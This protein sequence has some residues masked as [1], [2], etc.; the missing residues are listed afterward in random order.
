MMSTWLL[1]LKRG[2]V[3]VGSFHNLNRHALTWFWK[4]VRGFRLELVSWNGFFCRTGFSICF[5]AFELGLSRKLFLHHICYFLN[6][7]V[8]YWFLLLRLLALWLKQGCNFVFLLRTRAHHIYL[9]KVITT[10]KMFLC[11]VI[12]CS[13]I[14]RLATYSV[15]IQV[16]EHVLIELHQLIVRQTDRNRIFTDC[17]LN[18]VLA[19][20]V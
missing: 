6:W 17:P 11:F 4:N 1:R 10:R 16:I 14:R 2:L 3:A 12:L 20:R 18:V 9:V 8:I 5:L 7:L 19:Q 13:T 15:H